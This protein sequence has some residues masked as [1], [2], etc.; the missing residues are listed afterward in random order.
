MS[1]FT[2]FIEGMMSILCLLPSTGHTSPNFVKPARIDIKEVHQV[3]S[4]EAWV[5]VGLVTKEVARK[6]VDKLPYHKQTKL[7]ALLA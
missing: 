3:N 5:E 4:H 1:K 2:V 6:Q 7:K